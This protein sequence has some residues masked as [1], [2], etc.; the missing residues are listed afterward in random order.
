MSFFAY[1]IFPLNEARQQLKEKLKRPG[2]FSDVRS[3]II[4]EL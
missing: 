3:V 2:N 4:P 1:Y